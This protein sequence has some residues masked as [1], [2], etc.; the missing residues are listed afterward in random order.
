MHSMHAFYARILCMHVWNPCI[1][2]IHACYAI[3]SCMLAYYAYMVCMQSHDWES[4]RQNNCPKSSSGAPRPQ[5]ED[6]YIFGAPLQP[7]RRVQKSRI[8]NQKLD[9]KSQKSKIKNQ[10]SNINNQKSPRPQSGDSYSFGAHIPKVVTVVHLEHPGPK[11][12]KN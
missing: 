11:K 3:I 1:S 5:R 4:V 10:K 2:C 9:I 7:S 12:L 6:S 8:K